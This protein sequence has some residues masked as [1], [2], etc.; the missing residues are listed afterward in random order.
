M[1]RKYLYLLCLSIGCLAA[2]AQVPLDHLNYIDS[3]KKQLNSPVNA[4]I[5][6]KSSYQL[7]EYYLKIDSTKA[8]MY[9]AKGLNHSGQDPF[10]NAVFLYYKALIT[11]NNHPKLAKAAFTK[12]DWALQKFSTKEAYLFRSMCWYNYAFQ[13]YIN[14]QSKESVAVILHQAIPLALKSGNLAF[15]GKNYYQ[16]SVAFKELHQYDKES[17]YLNKAIS[18]LKIAKA[19]HYLAM[20]YQSMAEN[21]ISLGKLDNA[22]KNLDSLRLLLAPYPKSNSWLVYYAA[23]A[24][25]YNVAFQYDSSLRVIEKGMLVSKELKGTYN[26]E[27]LLLQKFYALYN[28]KRYAEAKDVA[29]LLAQSKRFMVWNS[30]RLQIYNG[31]AISYAAM[32]NKTKAYD[33]LKLYNTLNDSINNNKLKETV[34]LLEVKYRTA[35]NQKKIVALNAENERS[36]LAS[37]NNRLLSWLLGSASVFLLVLATFGW[38]FYSNSKKLALQKEVNHK[39]QLKELDQQQQLKIAAVMLDVKEEEQQRV[40]RDLHDGLGGNLAMAK[41]HLDN[42]IS[43]QPAVKDPALLHVMGQLEHSITELRQIAYDMMPGML[44]KMGLQ[45]SLNDLCESLSSNKRTVYFQCLD[46]KDTIPAKEQL[47]IYRIIQEALANAVK[48]AAAQHILLQ[49]SQDENTFFITVEDDGIGFDANKQLERPG[50]GLSN[51]QSRVAYLKGKIEILSAE[52]KQGTSINIELNVN[53]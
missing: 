18:T 21:D 39:Q 48:H 41:M 45:A 30:N 35:E 43:E 7:A 28:T 10:L 51:I 36:K 13:L 3:L 2:N 20:V 11:I 23:A 14:A 5:K 27:R 53:S 34:N 16:L 47:I 38:L 26:E 40:A 1:M 4:T 49:C 33:W 29:L 32:N 31:L 22:K 17:S 12:A 6:A 44:Q 25:R 24:L 9:L 19:P 15:L 42:Y 50:L 46:M 37:K 52:D 8:K